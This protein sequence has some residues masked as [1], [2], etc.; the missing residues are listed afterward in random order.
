MTVELNVRTVS[1]QTERLEKELAA[2]AAHIEADKAF[3]EKHDKRLQS[4]CNEILA[5]KQRVVEI[6]GPEWNKGGERAEAGQKEVDEAVERL[7]REMGEMRGLVSDLSSALDKLPTAAEAESLV[8]RSR[9]PASA[10]N[11][12]AT[13]AAAIEQ[14]SGTKEARSIKQR[15][16]DTIASTRRWNSDHK[17][18]K[19][20]DAVFIANYLKQQSKRDPQMAVYI[21]RTIQKHVQNSGRRP[22]TR[23]RPKSLEQFCRMLVWKDVLDTAELVLILRYADEKIFQ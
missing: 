10:S 17:T 15:I 2:L 6:Q 13:Q 11:G 18:T 9:A 21:Q 4:L 5:V 14:V 3:R 19:L 20:T 7:R 22:R 16:E 8:R 23:A 1:A 12:G